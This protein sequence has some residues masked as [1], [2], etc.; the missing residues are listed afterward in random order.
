M[1]MQYNDI[2]SHRSVFSSIG[3]MSQPDMSEIQ[4]ERVEDIMK[5]K[6]AIEVKEKKERV[7]K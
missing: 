4:K 5:S 7:A 3:D 6:F 1:F 2:V